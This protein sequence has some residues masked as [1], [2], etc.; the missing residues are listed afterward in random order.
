MK[1]IEVST[2]AEDYTVERFE[3]DTCLDKIRKEYLN[4]NTTE[5][6]CRKC[7]CHDNNWTCPPFNE[8][9]TGVWDKYENIKIIIEKY[10]FTREFLEEE[11]TA[12]ELMEYSFDLIHG[13][14][15]VIEDELYRLEEELNGEFLTS[16]PCV[17]CSVCQRTMNRECVMPDKR[18][19]AMESLG[20]NA[21]AIAKEYFNL[22]LQWIKGNVKPEYLIMMV[23][24][25]Y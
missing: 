1:T 9:Q 8:E 23:S 17:N 3:H 15:K 20:A 4:F 19:Y 22:D 14:K 11:T 21:V 12:E 2:M 7:R 16:G 24:V 25:L 18:K 13:Q 6:N 10:N 5:H